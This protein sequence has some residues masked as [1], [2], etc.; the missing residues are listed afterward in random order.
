MIPGC[1]SQIRILI[2]LR[3]P[4]DDDDECLWDDDGWGGRVTYPTYRRMESV[5]LGWSLPCVPTAPRGEGLSAAA[6]TTRTA[7]GPVCR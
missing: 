7:A 6:A 1:S 4:D 3:I 2:F 5:V